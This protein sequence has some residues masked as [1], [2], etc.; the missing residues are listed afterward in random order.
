MRKT[1]LGMPRWVAAI[2]ACG[3]ALLVTRACYRAYKV[4]GGSGAPTI[5]VGDHIFA[6]RTFGA[7]PRRG[8]VIVFAF[9]ENKRQDF[10]KRTIAIGGDKL[11][12]IGGRPVING[13]LVPRCRVGRYV[14][15]GRP[16]EM[17]LEYLEGQAY[18][19]L[20]D[21]A[22]EEKACRDDGECGAGQACRAGICGALQ[23]PF[24]VK[25]GEIWV[26]GDNRNNSHDSRS[27]RGGLG[28]GVPIEDVHGFGRMIW[29]SYD[30]RGGIASERMFASVSGPPAL[31]QAAAATLQPGI[32]KCLREQ[33]SIEKTTPPK[34]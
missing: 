11:E 3:V 2:A 4:P 34:R 8:D 12:V 30:D 16:F 17:Y 22:I 32:D 24:E 18:G 31:P 26:M 28:A 33:P 6:R 5:L 29:L 27:W 25:P 14:F 9:P 1:V 13:W 20:F 10:V 19:T 21:E 15:D 7:E 23:G